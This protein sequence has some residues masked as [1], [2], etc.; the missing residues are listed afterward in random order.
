MPLRP[1]VERLWGVVAEDLRS[2]MEGQGMA[3]PPHLPLAGQLCREC[4]AWLGWVCPEPVLPEG[5]QA[6]VLLT[7]ASWP[8]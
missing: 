7:L 3:S 1:H 6:S 4:Q 8:L 2:C 5:Q